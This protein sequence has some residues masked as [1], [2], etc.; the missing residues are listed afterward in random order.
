VVKVSLRVQPSR[1]PVK[2]HL[3][4]EATIAVGGFPGL[5]EPGTREANGN[6]VAAAG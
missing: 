5:S 2:V 4:Y 6:L 3:Y 1:G